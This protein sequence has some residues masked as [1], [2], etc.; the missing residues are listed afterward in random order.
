MA[1]RRRTRTTRNR[2]GRFVKRSARKAPPIPRRRRAARRRTRR[3]AVTRQAKKGPTMARRRRYFRRKASAT[4][5]RRRRSLRSGQ[6]GTAGV[7]GLVGVGIGAAS[8]IGGAA[9]LGM[10]AQAAKIELPQVVKDFAPMAGAGVIA[11]LGRLSP[12]WRSLAIPALVGAAAIT[13]FQKFVAPRM[14]GAG[15]YNRLRGA[16]NVARLMGTPAGA[17]NAARVLAGVA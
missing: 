1:R 10:A 2:K 17:G 15:A 12:K 6:R 11:V 9:L 14:A 3:A 13:A 5:T 7:G 8:A 4:P 16:G